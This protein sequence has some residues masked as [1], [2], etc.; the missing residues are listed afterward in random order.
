VRL[1]TALLL[2]A[3]LGCSLPPRELTPEKRQPAPAS[4]VQSVVFESLARSLEAGTFSDSSQRFIKVAGATLRAERVTPP[5]GYDAALE[6]WMQNHR[7]TADE[8]AAL[9]ARLREF[10]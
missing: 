4:N 5:A 1:L 7:P 2:S 9:A 8:C 10:K 3:I 6:P